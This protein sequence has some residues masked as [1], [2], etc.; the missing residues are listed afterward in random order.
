[1]IA[2]FIDVRTAIDALERGVAG[3]ALSAPE[4][5]F[6]A[7]AK[8]HPDLSSH[9]LQAKGR[10]PSEDAQ[11]ATILLG[12]RAAIAVLPTDPQ[13]GAPAKAAR[14]ALAAA[15]AEGDQIEQLL[16]GVLV[17]EAFTGDNDPTHFDADFVKESFSELTELARLDEEAV[18]TLIEEFGKG[19]K[20]DQRPL[21]LQC[22]ETLF[23]TAWG[24]GT[25]SVNVEHVE[26]ALQA[27]A[28]D[29]A[30]L[31]AAKQTLEVLLRFLSV[32]RLIG[33][34]RL[35][36]LLTHLRAWSIGDND[37]QDDEDDDDD[38]EE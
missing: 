19:A 3:V 15:G 38:D 25:Q 5:A 21:Y 20:P 28:S 34:L 22:A 1:V 18:D 33:P 27:L 26:D 37:A 16:G 6:V 9:V 32:H 36:R 35:E 14:E 10:K 2:A 31:E 4:A 17:E 23:Q 8:A 30:E 13:L 24:D 29:P 7:A 11:N 12:V